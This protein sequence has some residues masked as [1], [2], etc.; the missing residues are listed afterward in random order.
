M[1]VLEEF[2]FIN[3]YPATIFC[4]SRESI[5]RA[6]GEIKR[7][8]DEQITFFHNAGM[9]LEAK[10]IDE[11][12]HYDIEMIQELGY[13][14]GVENYSRYFDGREPGT[15]PYCLLDY[16]PDDMLVVVDESHV[17]IPQIHAMYG[18]DCLPPATTVRSPS[19]SGSRKSACLS[20]IAVCQRS[21]LTSNSG[22][23]RRSSS[24]P[25]LPNTNWS[26]PK[27]LWLSN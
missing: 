8:L 15:P 17:T 9:E 6:I 27:A 16:F 5:E 26:S 19:R 14:S 24:P 12:V 2:E 7:D 25:H 4:T 11:R 20:A 22:A 13:C 21:G 3:I 1:N 10:R 23:V 18:G